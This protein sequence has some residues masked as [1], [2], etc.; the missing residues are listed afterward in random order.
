M[1]RIILLMLKARLASL[2]WKQDALSL[3]H[4]SSLFPLLSTDKTFQGLWLE[5]ELEMELLGMNSGTLN[6]PRGSG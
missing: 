2:F 1:L 4:P 6:R 5:L 3:T